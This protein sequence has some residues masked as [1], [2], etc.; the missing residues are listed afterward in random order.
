MQ[1]L[2]IVKPFEERKDIPARV[3]PGVIRLVMDQFILQGAEEALRHRIVVAI[4]FAAHARRHVQCCESTLIR[5][6]AVLGAL[7][8]VMD[9]TG[10]YAPLAHRYGRAS[11]VRC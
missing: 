1:P 8:R 2:A 6:A 11:S 3:V 5:Q 9:K 10:L 4:P 7:V